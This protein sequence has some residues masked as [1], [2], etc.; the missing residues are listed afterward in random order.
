MVLKYNIRGVTL[1]VGY[2]AVVS[3]LEKFNMSDSYRYNM[4]DRGCAHMIYSWDMRFTGLLELSILYLK[5]R[6]SRIIT[7]NG[8]I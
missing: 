4:S 7:Q 5:I 2:E 8:L 6:L 3:L 1:Q